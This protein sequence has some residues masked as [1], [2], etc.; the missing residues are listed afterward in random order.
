MMASMADTPKART[1]SFSRDPVCGKPVDPNRTAQGYV[2][3]DRVY[4]FCSTGC[5]RRFIAE[6]EAFAAETPTPPSDPPSRG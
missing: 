1:D 6:P 3:G 5:L 4:Y 2:H